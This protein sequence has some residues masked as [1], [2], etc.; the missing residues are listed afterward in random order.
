MRACCT[1]ST[2]K[3]SLKFD[4]LKPCK[5]ELIIERR[6]RARI[7]ATGHGT[8]GVGCVDKCTGDHAVGIAQTRLQNVAHSTGKRRRACER[9]H[10]VTLQSRVKRVMQNDE[11]TGRM[12]ASVPA[13]VTAS[14]ERFVEHLLH[15]SARA[16]AASGPTKTIQPQHM[17]VVHAHA[18]T[19]GLQ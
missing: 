12:H 4:D 11:E 15:D 14:M 5:N 2:K 16:L 9:T 3:R 17:C 19:R 6:R 13:A 1:A 10:L 18:Y 8:V 7:S